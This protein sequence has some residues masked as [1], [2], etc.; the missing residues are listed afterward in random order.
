[1]AKM[2]KPILFI[3]AAG[4]MCRFAV[5]RF[6]NASDAKLVLAD[7]NTKAV[8]SLYADLPGRPKILQLDLYDHTALVSAIKDAAFVVLAAGPYIR[9][10]IPVI[11]A[12]LE[13]KVPY[14]DF[15]DDVESTQAALDL[16]EQAK[17]AGVPCYIGCGASP[18]MTNVMVMDATRELDS[19]SAIDVCWQVGQ[20][21]GGAGKA[22]LEHTIHIAAGPC[23]TWANE[24]PTLA[25]TYID[26][27]YAPMLG[28]STEMVL[29]ETAHPEPI[30]LPRI[31][32]QATRIRCLGGLFPQA[33]WGNV[34]GLA[35][36]VRRGA[37][38]MNEAIDFLWDLR[39]GRVPPQ[40]FGQMIR[41]LNEQ[42]DGKSKYC[43]Q[44]SQ[45]VLGAGSSNGPWQFAVK[46][47]ADQVKNGEC[48]KEEVLDFILGASRASRGEKVQTTPT[49]LCIRAVGTRNG[50][51]AVIIKRTPTPGP[52]AVYMKTLGSS[53]G[54]ACAAF[55]VMAL[56][57]Q[58]KNGVLAPEDW[59][60][61]ED[62]YQALER[63]G[64]PRYEIVESLTP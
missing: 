50:H 13:A 57:T 58:A 31:F 38:T 22:V 10:S 26:T 24:K 20:Q 23:L 62:F 2:A 47:L 5:Q 49:S 56:E 4:E 46:G 15:D 29:H 43:E 42:T 51:P 25:E 6:V 19:V 48:T 45:L 64:V 34:R 18:G 17:N 53:T 14:L 8:E 11:K 41:E 44:A 63:V 7:I 36:A 3:G 59:A 55:L 60:K 9:T 40:V 32:P 21:S 54:T 33:K 16:N 61:P 30:T 28:K 12:C 1:M 37:L 52:D 35:T 39:N 27:A